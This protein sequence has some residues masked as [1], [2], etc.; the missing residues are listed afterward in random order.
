MRHIVVIIIII[1]IIIIIYCGTILGMF[2]SYLA[3][4]GTSKIMTVLK[5]AYHTMLLIGYQL[6][7]T[8]ANASEFKPMPMGSQTLTYA[9]AMGEDGQW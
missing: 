4:C 5:F 2:L 7:T 6:L 9:T 1:I 8:H 3:V